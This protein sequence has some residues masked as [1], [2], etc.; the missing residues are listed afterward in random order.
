MV[1]ATCPVVRLAAVRSTPGLDPHYPFDFG[2]L[3]TIADLL[4]D[5]ARRLVLEAQ[6]EAQAM[7]ER[8]RIY[9]EVATRYPPCHGKRNVIQMVC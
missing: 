7:M 4:D 8:A 6:Q 9:R 2:K 1:K 5:H 3:K